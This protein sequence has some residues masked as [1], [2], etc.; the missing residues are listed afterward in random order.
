MNLQ[1]P[2]IKSVQLDLTTLLSDMLVPDLSSGRRPNRF[3]ASVLDWVP[4]GIDLSPCYSSKMEYVQRQQVVDER[5]KMHTW[6]I[7]SLIQHQM[8]ISS[9]QAE[10]SHPAHFLPPLGSGVDCLISSPTPLCPPE[11]GSMPLFT[12]SLLHLSRCASEVF[13]SNSSPPPIS[14]LRGQ[15]PSLLSSSYNR[16]FW[17]PGT[18][19][20]DAW[21]QIT[22]KTQGPIS[23]QKL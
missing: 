14:D 3:P 21:R 5:N 1:N 16:T 7:F 4:F 10:S 15:A 6:H 19:L 2:K 9:S 11:T 22:W 8:G 20:Q 13:I 17:R 23:F 18:D 12:S